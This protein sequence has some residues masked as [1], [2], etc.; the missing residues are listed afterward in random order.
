MHV[1]QDSIS[2]P[3]LPFFLQYALDAHVS[4]SHERDATSNKFATKS[5]LRTAL[6]GDKMEKNVMGGAC[7]TYGTKM[8]SIHG[9]GGET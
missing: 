2:A 6:F 4:A 3:L 8:R 9:F 7:S 1:L 5:L